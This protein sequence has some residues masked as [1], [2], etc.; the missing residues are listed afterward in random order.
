MKITMSGLRCD[1]WDWCTYPA[2]NDRLDNRGR[3]LVICGDVMGKLIP[4]VDRGRTVSLSISDSGPGMHI[5]VCASQVMTKVIGKLAWRVETSS[6]VVKSGDVD[7]DDSRYS[8]WFEMYILAADIIRAAFDLA[9]GEIVNLYIS[10][11]QD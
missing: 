3:R 10:A 8:V 9:D 7:T 2:N 1:G 4:N 6:A 5:Q 11:T